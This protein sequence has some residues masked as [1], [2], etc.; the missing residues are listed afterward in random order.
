MHTISLFQ[1]KQTNFSI[2]CEDYNVLMIV[3]ICLMFFLISLTHYVDLLNL[4]CSH[5]IQN[6][7]SFTKTISKLSFLKCGKTFGPSGIIPTYNI[8]T[9]VNFSWFQMCPLKTELINLRKQKIVELNFISFCQYVRRK[10]S[11][12]RLR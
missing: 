12:F 2:T 1:R 9:E 5:D 11:D 8:H 3:F 6:Q 4:Y 7:V 10:R